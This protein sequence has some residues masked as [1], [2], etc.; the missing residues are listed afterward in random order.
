MGL[1]IIYS[2]FITLWAI[3]MTIEYNKVSSFKSGYDKGWNDCNKHH[4][5]NEAS[6]EEQLNEIGWEKVD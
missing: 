3:A 1:L 4:C 5:S 2:V 6:F